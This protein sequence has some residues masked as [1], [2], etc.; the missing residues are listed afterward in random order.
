MQ[1]ETLQGKVDLEK[2][3]EIRRIL[4]RKYGARGNFQKIFNQWDNE[5]KG[6]VSVHNLFDMLKKFGINVNLDEA[7]VLVASADHDRSNDLNL[8]EFLELIF[9]DNEALNVDLAKI[10]GIKQFNFSREKIII[11]KNKFFLK[12]KKKVS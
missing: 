1:H 9:T 2:I 6:A 10:P 11:E 3:K 5:S 8:D 4:R 12:M 7:R